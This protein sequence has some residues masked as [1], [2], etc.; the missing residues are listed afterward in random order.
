ME[1]TANCVVW[2][3][4]EW[5]ALPLGQGLIGLLHFVA[6]PFLCC[7]FVRFEEGQGLERSA[8]AD[9]QGD[10]HIP[11]GGPAKFQAETDGSAG[12]PSCKGR[13]CA[14]RRMVR[15]EKRTA[16][17]DAIHFRRAWLH[18]MFSFRTMQ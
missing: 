10:E 11:V 6:L 2:K 17:Y 12:R 5:G 3:C 16:R 4:A 13:E 15:V 14:Y 18:K 8:V 9:F 7:A 1:T